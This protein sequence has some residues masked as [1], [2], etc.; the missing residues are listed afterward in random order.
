MRLEFPTKYKVIYPKG[1]KRY[2][3]D[4]Y[5]REIEKSLLEASNY[6]CMY[7]GRNLK[8]DDDIQLN[9]EHSIEK[10]GYEKD[11]IVEFLAHC[12]FNLSVACQSCNQKYKTRMIEKLGVDMVKKEV[13]CEKLECTKP[14]K[15]YLE[16]TNEYLKINSIILQ[17]NG[18]CFEN[19]GECGIEYDLLKNIFRPI[20]SDDRAK[21]NF[22]EEHIS[23][24]HLNR[25]MF[26]ECILKICEIIITIIDE[27]GYDIKI[28][29][30]IK[31]LNIQRFDNVLG[32]IYV[33][34]I[35]DNFRDVSDLYEFCKLIILIE[36][37]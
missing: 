9:I 33:K 13:A 11:K 12:K 8:I 36:Y 20:F 34:F 21:I 25:E 23:R 22:I 18:V 29:A 35:K 19:S 32:E 4:K 37:I 27:F 26:S 30:I 1:N 31:V 5:K 3:G 6:Y 28:S 17:P 16:I 24:F 7:C 10:G 2:Y 15:E 14:C